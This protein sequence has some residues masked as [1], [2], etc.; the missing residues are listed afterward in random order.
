MYPATQ[1]CAQS[2]RGRTSSRLP[3]GSSAVRSRTIR[4]ICASSP[5]VMSATEARVAKRNRRG[6]AGRGPSEVL[7]ARTNSAYLAGMALPS[8]TLRLSASHSS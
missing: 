4:S 1:A 8:A 5:A 3:S 6:V 2:S 7:D